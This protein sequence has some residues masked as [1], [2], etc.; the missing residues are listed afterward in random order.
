MAVVLLGANIELF[1]YLQKYFFFLL[2]QSSNI[3]I[4]YLLLSFE[5]CVSLSVVAG[6][7][8]GR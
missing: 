3:K 7:E 1:V 4:L 5:G 8:G 2:N 6:A